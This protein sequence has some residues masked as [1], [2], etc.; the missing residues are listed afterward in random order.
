M[1]ANNFNHFNLE[2]ATSTGSFHAQS[3]LFY[4]TT[5]RMGASRVS[6]SGAYTQAGYLL[7]G[8]SRPYN[9]K[10]GVL[11]RIKPLEPFGNG[12]IGAWEVAGRWSCLD[13]NSNNIRGGRINNLTLG[14]NWYLNNHTKFQFN[15]IHAFL[16]KSSAVT[17]PVINNSNADI[18]AFRAQ[19]DF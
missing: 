13:L 10:A 6:F 11:G 2:L 19:V 12:G 3:E 15:Y 18:I 8:E 7:T 14:L 16:N 1:P 9:R 4:A 5:S 17:G